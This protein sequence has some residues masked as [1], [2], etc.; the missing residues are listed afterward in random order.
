MDFRLLLCS[1]RLL[2]S[3]SAAVI[4]FEKERVK[5]FEPSTSTLARGGACVRS[6]EADGGYAS[7]EFALHRALHRLAAAAGRRG[8]GSAGPDCGP[9]QLPT[10]GQSTCLGGSIR[11]RYRTQDTSCCRNLKP[12][13]RRRSTGPRECASSIGSAAEP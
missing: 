1:L 4:V 2:L 9:T 10:A 3:R 13:S 6:R 7:R 8:H 11:T 12:D 5:G